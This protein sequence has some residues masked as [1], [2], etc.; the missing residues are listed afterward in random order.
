[1]YVQVGPSAQVRTYS[2][3]FFRY[4]SILEN[5]QTVEWIRPTQNLLSSGKQ[6]LENARRLIC[7]AEESLTSKTSALIT[8]YNCSNES[9]LKCIAQCKC[10]KSTLET[11]LLNVS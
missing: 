4:V 9:F 6:E 10:V 5:W 2:F 8:Q 11:E 7:F 1:M 3:N